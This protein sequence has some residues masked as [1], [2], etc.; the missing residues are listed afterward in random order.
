MAIYVLDTDVSQANGT[1]IFSDWTALKAKVEADNGVVFSAPV[2]IHLKASTGLPFNQQMVINSFAPSQS[3]NLTI[4]AKRTNGYP[5]VITETGLT[6]NFVCDL[7]DDYIIFQGEN[8]GDLIVEADTGSATDKSLLTVQKATVVVNNVI[9]DGKNS[10]RHAGVYVP[11]GDC[12]I[13]NSIIKGCKRGFYGASRGTANFNQCTFV[14]NSLFRGAG[15]VNRCMFITTPFTGGDG[16]NG[17]SVTNNNVYDIAKASVIY[18]ADSAT[19]DVDSIFSVNVANSLYQRADG[20]YDVL[21]TSTTIVDRITVVGAIGAG[22]TVLNSNIAPVINDQTFDVLVDT[23]LT[24][25]LSSYASDANGDTLTYSVLGDADIVQ[26]SSASQ[27]VFNSSVLGVHTV[28][29]TVDDGNGGTDSAVFTINV[30]TPATQPTSVMVIGN[31][32]SSAPAGE[33][34]GV[35]NSVYDEV[36]QIMLEKGKNFTF[37]EYLYGGRQ[38]ADHAADSALMADIPNYDLLIVQGGTGDDTNYTTDVTPI[39]NLANNAALW[40]RWERA[41][42]VGEYAQLKTNITAAATATGSG[43]IEMGDVWADLRAN[44][45]IDLFY[46]LTHQ[47]LNGSYVNAL[48]IYRYLTGESVASVTYTPALLTLSAGDITAIKTAVDAGITQTYSAVV[49][50]ATVNITSSTASVTQGNTASFSAT[51]TDTVSGDLTSSITWVDDLGNT[52]GAGGSINPTMSVSGT[53]SVIAKVTGSDGLVSSASVSV[54]VNPSG[55]TAPVASNFV[56]NVIYNEAF[57]QKSLTS[58]VTDDGTV[59]WSTLQITQPTNGVATIDSNSNSTVNLDYS[60]SNFE[61]NDS[62]TFSV[63]DT[64][65]LRSNTATVTVNVHKDISGVISGNSITRGTSA[66]ITMTNYVAGVGV[67]VYVKNV[68]GDNTEYP[69]VVTLNSNSTITFNVPVIADMPAMTNAQI[70]VRPIISM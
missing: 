2:E 38:L 23:D 62:F 57:T 13:N 16:I 32:L 64:Q 15:N 14:N 66:S 36:A 8:L 56:F 10:T 49:R 60:G 45:T 50:T 68:N 59:D 61:G 51:A 37:T 27:Y 20:G 1:T 26:G 40:L 4:T 47:N 25:E 22:T 39:T 6:N 48:C 70:I 43:L 55:N 11:T 5:F 28:N 29:I 3:N 69:C 42:A 41:G 19:A 34:S 52:L 53:H 63:A 54:I 18:K 31:S 35:T 46:D 17:G 21:S 65:G 67:E 24:I 44:T 7:N 58:Y 33:P 30:N 12:N 9:L